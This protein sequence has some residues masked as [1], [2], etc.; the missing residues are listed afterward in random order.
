MFNDAITRLIR[1]YVPLAVAWLATA[2]GLPEEWTGQATAAM[3]T[4]VF[5]LYYFV[6]ALLE[7][8]VSPKFGWLLGV[9]KTKTRRPEQKAGSGGV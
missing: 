9:P 5:A 6:A 7:E 4:L 3:T 1:T 8:K 2:L